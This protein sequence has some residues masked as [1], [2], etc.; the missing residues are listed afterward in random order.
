MKVKRRRE[1][2]KTTWEIVKE[3]RRSW[4]KSSLKIENW[5]WK[6]NGLRRKGKA[7]T[8]SLTGS[9]WEKMTWIGRKGARESLTWRKVKIGVGAFKSKKKWKQP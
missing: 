6:L 3:T 7:K 5:K 2:S 8:L 9:K 1:S 4:K